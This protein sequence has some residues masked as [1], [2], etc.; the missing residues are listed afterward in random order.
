MKTTV[1]S[2]H[3]SPGRPEDFTPLKMELL[4]NYPAQSIVWN[5]LDR[6]KPGQAT[7]SDIA[8]GQSSENE[9]SLVLIGYSFG[10]NRL[11]LDA[12]NFLKFKGKIAQI[13]LISP[14]LVAKN[15][16]SS[17][18][19][20]VLSTPLLG[21]T[22]LKGKGPK[23]IKEMLEKSSFPDTIPS[24]YQS[25]LTDYI[26][27]TVLKHSILE[28]NG[29][30]QF[31]FSQVIQKLNEEK[32]PVTILWGEK[33]QTSNYQ[34]QIAPLA[35]LPNLNLEKISAKGHAL[36][37]TAKSLVHSK[38]LEIVGQVATPIG[39]AQGISE[40]NNVFQFLNKHLRNFPDRK[41]LTWVQPEELM[42]W[43]F[44]LT[45]P[46]PHK[47]IS[48]KE[49]HH[50]IGV[51]GTGLENL[52]VQKGDRAIVFIPMS[53][54]LYAAMFA[55]QKIG[56]VPVF[57]DSW[58]RRDQLGI[59]AKVADP[60]IIISVEKAFNYLLDVPEIQNIPIRIV[61]GPATGQYTARLEALMQ[62]S[63]ICP[64]AAVEMEHTALITFTTGSSGTP[65]GADRTHRFLAAQHYA[66]NRHLPYNDNDVDLPVF[67]IFSLNNLAAGVNT[68]I[69]AIDV[70]VPNE[71][72]GLILMAQIFQEK[73]TCTTLSPSL[74]NSLSKFC[75]DNGMTLKGMKR[76]VTGGAPV[77]RD[78]I[79]RMK[80]VAPDAEILVL[81]GSTEVEPMAHI[82]SA[83]MLGRKTQSDID[84]E[85]VE[86]GVDVGFM[87]EGLRVKFIKIDKNPVY[88]K[89]TSDW[90]KMEVAQGEVGEI[91]VAGEH[92]CQGY[93]RNEEAFYRAKIRD[94]E[95]VV[96]H[97]TGDLGKYDKDGHLW[98]VG[99]VH[100]AINRG[101]KY[102]FPVRAE[103]VLKKIPH[104]KLAAY[105]GIPDA[106]LGEKTLAAV[107]LANQDADH[108]VVIK[109][110]DR[111]LKK[112]EVACDKILVVDKIPMDPRHHSK[113]EYDV[114][115]KDLL[116]KGLV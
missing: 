74:F 20:L 103:I 110:I 37:W 25:R 47:S 41:I 10:C 111:L 78:D 46:L 65:K 76:I 17:L 27:P 42:K 97:R 4:K 113:V 31:P 45:T 19:S 115:R 106:T 93:F 85:Y 86:E 92:V 96:W 55:L 68:I 43:D 82:E 58:A 5:D 26:A 101:G 91:I 36:L 28:K 2:Y 13:I 6:T 7:L 89:T 79:K 44:K 9:H 112:N 71:R 102:Y 98:L 15:P 48:V 52:G 1:V 66:L 53:L 49:L 84:P 8:E 77:S 18:T 34:E 59:S 30:D 81:Y 70:G 99:R 64:S 33:D 116:A 22:I 95:N 100:N 51:I 54:Y 16:P 88:I 63:Q 69:P 14:Y 109:E 32:I 11:L 105:L 67:P 50:L 24:D 94:Y 75:L 61:A 90:Q 12:L 23:A 108:S 72:D 87:D 57:L 3:G 39:Y 40:Q 56:A 104:V 60:K 73:V 38:V 21:D 62:N 107:T 29:Q 83:Q 114:L 35:E 80:S